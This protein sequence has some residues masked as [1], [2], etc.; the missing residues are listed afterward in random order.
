[1]NRRQV[2]A[3]AGHSSSTVGVAPGIH[4]ID[5]HHLGNP[6]V[7][8]AGV[9]DTGAGLAI[10]DPGP[11]SSL[12]NLLAGLEASGRHPSEVRYLLLTH[13]H[14][15]HAGATG[16]MV[17]RRPDL[18]VYVHQ[19]G[20]P[21]LADPTKLLASAERLYGADLQG[22]WGEVVPVPPANL[23]PLEGGERL[24][25]GDVTLEVAYTPG[26]AWHH[27]SYLHAS[28]G[29]AFVGDVAG[30]HI[31]GRDYLFPPTPPPD[32]DLES[33]GASLDRIAA[34]RAE[35]L[36]LTH[37]G[38]SAAVEPHLAEMR[39]RLIAWGERV[40]ASLAEPGDDASRAAAFIQQV[41]EELRRRLPPEEALRFKQGAGLKFCWYGLARYWRKRAAP[42][43]A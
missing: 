12:A 5:V 23:R 9:L 34:W 6:H 13:I 33:W 21:H 14:L 29:T 2:A 8:A 15:D 37:F 25:L 40:R 3:G 27:V 16:A 39:E 35:R 30:I 36:F 18:A 31:S 41:G 1:V 4:L 11:E 22:L 7:I 38:P 17:R 32:I 19:R 28:T 10:V 26:H 24:A 43:N 20:A 42:S